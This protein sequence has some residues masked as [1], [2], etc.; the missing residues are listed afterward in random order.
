MRPGSAFPPSCGPGSIS[1]WEPRSGRSLPGFVIVN[2]AVSINS[3]SDT[4]AIQQ[5]AWRRPLAT[6]FRVVQGAHNLVMLTNL[7]AALL[8]TLPNM[9]GASNSARVSLTGVAAR[10]VG[11]YAGAILIMVA[12]SPKII[13]LVVAIP[14]PAL[15]AFMVVLMAM[16]FVQGMSIVFR[17][18]VGPAEGCGRGGV[19]LDGNRLPAPA[20]LPGYSQRDVGNAA[21]QRNDHRL[22]FHHPA[23]HA[24]GHDIFAAQ[25]P[26]SGPG[27][28]LPARD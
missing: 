12:F 20:D 24:D 21:Q 27:P 14:R 19:S 23:H 28:V 6:D 7:L 22:G 13:A 15:V 16:L 26:E 5:V 18:G 25:T 3:I 4:V 8:G 2:L 9:I 17:D 1:A 10:R 11:V